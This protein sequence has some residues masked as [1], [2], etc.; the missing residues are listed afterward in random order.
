MPSLAPVQKRSPIPRGSRSA[1]GC[2]STC[3]PGRYREP[4]SSYGTHQITASRIAVR[5]DRSGPRR[6]KS[7]ESLELT[8]GTTRNKARLPTS[9]KSIG[10]GTPTGVPEPLPAL[11]GSDRLTHPRQRQIRAKCLLGQRSGLSPSQREVAIFAFHPNVV[12]ET[13]YLNSVIG[14]SKT[15]PRSTDQV[16]AG[17]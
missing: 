9:W 13:T 6:R 7:A 1:C 17:E 4:E 14:E 12:T 11:L 2:L 15:Q 16:F 5:L 3:P 10:G 8:E